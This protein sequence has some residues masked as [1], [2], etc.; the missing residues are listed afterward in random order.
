MGKSSLDQGAEFSPNEIYARIYQ[1]GESLTLS[2]LRSGRAGIS[3]TGFRG[4]S[5]AAQGALGT[6]AVHMRVCHHPPASFGSSG[7]TDGRGT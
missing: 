4:A 1:E 3:E 5:A 6:C 7:G 2:A